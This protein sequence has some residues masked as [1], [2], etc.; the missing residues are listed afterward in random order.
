MGR[1]LF[2]LRPGRDGGRRLGSKFRDHRHQGLRGVRHRVGTRSSECLS[3]QH[4]SRAEKFEELLGFAPAAHAERSA[5]IDHAVL[6]E[7]I[8]H[9][10]YATQGRVSIVSPAEKT[11]GTARELIAYAHRRAAER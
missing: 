10:A 5:G 3:T 8:P 4:R 7:V 11:D 9:P 1:F 6:D 2:P